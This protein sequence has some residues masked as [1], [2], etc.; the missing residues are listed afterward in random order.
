MG[1]VSRGVG[2]R[3]VTLVRASV[4]PAVVAALVWTALW[5]AQGDVRERLQK[6]LI[7]LLAFSVTVTPWLIE[8]YRLAG[9]PVLS[10]GTGMRSG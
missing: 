9:A 4:A 5:G 6:S 3:M 10:S 8:T 7:V 2:I 1:L